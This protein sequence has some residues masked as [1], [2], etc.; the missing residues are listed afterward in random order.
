MWH[1]RNHPDLQSIVFEPK[2][3]INADL[4]SCT[5]RDL[6]CSLIESDG[7]ERRIVVVVDGLE[8]CLGPA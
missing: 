2:W 5:S 8:N 1:S 7:F 6:A 4:F 3:L